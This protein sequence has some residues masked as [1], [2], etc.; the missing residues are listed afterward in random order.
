M[1]ES[2]IIVNVRQ[3]K[4]WWSQF[5]CIFFGTLSQRITKA[6]FH[7]AQNRL[8]DSDALE[9]QVVVEAF[10]SAAGFC[11]F[12]WKKLG[13]ARKVLGDNSAQLQLA[14]CEMKTKCTF[15]NCKRDEG[16]FSRLSA[17]LNSCEL[18]K[19][20]FALF[21]GCSESSND[22]FCC[23]EICWAV[24]GG[25]ALIMTFSIW[26]NAFKRVKI[27]HER[28]EKCCTFVRYSKGEF[29]KRIFNESLKKLVNFS[30]VKIKVDNESFMYSCYECLSPEFMH[31]ILHKETLFAAP[32]GCISSDF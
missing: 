14:V 16:K 6:N 9:N 7:I 29:V 27:F 5:N 20:F 32:E 15:Y 25:A 30:C 12:R 4:A 18:S 8:L 3:W 22:V 31:V 24:T 1:K 26:V 13:T 23:V 10:K 11:V 21:S 17:F 28:W 19:D 2:H